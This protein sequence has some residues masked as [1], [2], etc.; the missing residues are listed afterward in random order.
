MS[1]WRRTSPERTHTV[2]DKTIRRVAVFFLFIAAVLV[3]VAVMALRNVGKSV[4]DS[5]WVNHTHAVIL[6]TEAVRSALLTADGLLHTYVLTGD[7]RD[8][9]AC[10]EA[11][12]D[13]S[14]NLDIAKALTRFEPEQNKQL[15]GIETLANK[16]AEFIQGALAARKAGDIATLREM[17]AAD[18]GGTAIR[19]IQKAIDKLKGDELALLTDRDKASYL[20]AQATS[21]TVWTG[22]VLDV[23]L[24]AGAAWLVRDDLAARRLAA[25]ALQEAND[26]LEARVRERTAELGSANSRLSNENLERRWANHALEHQLRYNHLIVDSI[27]DLVLVLTAALNISR[28]NPAV[29]RVTGLEPAELVNKPLSRV[30]R[31]APEANAADAP[32]RD[33]IAQS[34]RDGRELQRR[35]AVV[36]DKR[37]RQMRALLSLFPL[38]DQDKVVGCVVT[39][40]IL[41][42][43]A[44]TAPST[45]SSG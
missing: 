33:P 8:M 12:S 21:W 16:R 23:L 42:P 17:L 19:D 3:A 7:A 1:T 13:A 24:L 31:L 20:Q 40:Q 41:S 43:Q 36:E 29:V 18:A 5:D 6:E 11:L 9:G 4:A 37:G 34:L 35:P 28:V 25:S 15:A 44:D 22:V 27:S 10:R 39:L 45:G 2:K 32:L 14:E 26:Q 30:A 38:R